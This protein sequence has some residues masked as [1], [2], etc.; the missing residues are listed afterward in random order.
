MQVKTATKEELALLIHGLRSMA[1]IDQITLQK[2]L[3]K[4]LEGE[5]AI[6]YG[7]ALAEPKP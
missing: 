1:V 2:R 7:V 6:R 3:L 4:Q 5:L